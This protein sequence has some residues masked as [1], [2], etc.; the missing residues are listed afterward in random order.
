VL[1]ARL[2][3]MGIDPLVPAVYMIRTSVSEPNGSARII[4]GQQWREYKT[5][6]LKLVKCFLLDY[7]KW[8]LGIVEKM[9]WA[10]VHSIPLTTAPA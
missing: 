10:F 9:R 3:V 6:W 2:P 4:S 8:H 7:S 1:N 5:E